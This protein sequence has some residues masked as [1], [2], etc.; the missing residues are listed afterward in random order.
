[1]KNEADTPPLCYKPNST[2]FEV[3]N[4]TELLDLTRPMT[5]KERLA[6]RHRELS[7]E[8]LKVGLL[9]ASKAVVQLSINPF[10]GPLT[11]R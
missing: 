9:F 1:M 2:S 7:N 11:N 4:I 5:K 6:Y 8:N 10:I 3:Y